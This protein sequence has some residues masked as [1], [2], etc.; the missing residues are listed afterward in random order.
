M[1]INCYGTID[2]LEPEYK[3]DVVN[4]SNKACL[5]SKQIIYKQIV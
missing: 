1:H 2:V 4:E 3:K 5:I